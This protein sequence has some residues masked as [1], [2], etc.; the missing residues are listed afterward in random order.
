MNPINV[1][2]LISF[3]FS[4]FIFLTVTLLNLPPTNP[5]ASILLALGMF[6]P[7]LGSFIVTKYVKKESFFEKIGLRSKINRWF[8]VSW[9]IFV[10]II[11]L[12]IFISTLFPKVSFSLKME[13]FFEKYSYLLKDAS[14]LKMKEQMESKPILFLILSIV[15]SLFA[16]ITINAIAAFGEESGWRG[17][18]LNEYKEKSFIE[19]SIR[20]GLV[21]GV[22]HSPIVAAGLNYPQHPQIGVFMMIIWCILLTFLF[23]YLRIKSKTVL[24]S[25][26]LHGTLNA[27]AG[28]SVLYIVG[29][30]DLT[31]GI[32]GLAGF[33]SLLIFN[34]AIFVYD[35]FIS[36]EKIVLSRVK[37]NLL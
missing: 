5:F 20:I 25:A 3:G 12:A 8:F 1:Y 2:F 17:F 4:W 24:S 16:G 10:F 37:D 22:W 7:F 35:I 32:T 13:G 36:K 19:A 26:V 14:S 29:G 23:N 15:Q 9:F 18:L 6:G 21:W 30:N 34:G 11:F 28:F 33:L 31:V 27:L